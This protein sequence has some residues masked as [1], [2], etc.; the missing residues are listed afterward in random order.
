LGNI[1]PIVSDSPEL[2]EGQP[3]IEMRNVSYSYNQ[4]NAALK[5]INLQ[6]NSGELVAILGRNG[7]GKTTLVRHIIGLLQPDQGQVIVAGRDVSVTPTHELAQDVG[8]CFQNPNHQ[9]VSFN[10]RD[11]MA[12]GLK[13]HDIDPAE[14]EARTREALEIVDMLDN[15]DAE[16]FDLGK[17]QKQRL[18]LAS[19]LTLK[20][21]ILV[22]DEPT[23]GQDPQMAKEIFEIIKRLN[24][25]GTTVLMITHNI[26][27]AATYAQ[28]AFVLQYGELVFDGSIRDLISNPDI[29]RENSLDLPDTTKVALMLSKHGVPP[30]IVTYEDLERSVRRLLEAS[31]GH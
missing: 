19:V 17:G 22:I 8:F 5:N 27:Y 3:V 13:A 15:I 18:A 4:R 16:V 2:V 24:E 30:W 11:E 21:R 31:N 9:I 25:I 26:E 7:S 12:F 23:T 10:V 29:M 14:F 20:P 1:Q 6:I 28:R